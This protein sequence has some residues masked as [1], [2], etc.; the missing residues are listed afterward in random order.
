MIKE[1]VHTKMWITCI[2]TTLP[3]KIIIFVIGIFQL[4]LQQDVMIDEFVFK[5]H[6]FHAQLFSPRVLFMHS[7]LAGLKGLEI[8]IRYTFTASC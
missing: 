3:R 7:W 8:Q 4:C 2:V 1:D 6:F 5:K